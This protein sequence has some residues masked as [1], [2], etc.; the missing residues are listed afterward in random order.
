MSLNWLIVHCTGTSFLFWGNNG[1]V[2]RELYSITNL[3]WDIIAGGSEKLSTKRAAWALKLLQSP[4]KRMTFPWPRVYCSL[5]IT[6]FIVRLYK[7][8]ANN[9]KVSFHTLMQ[10]STLD[11]SYRFSTSAAGKLAMAE[12]T[13]PLPGK[14]AELSNVRPMTE[15]FLS[16]VAA[17]NNPRLPHPSQQMA[18]VCKNMATAGISL[19]PCERSSVS[20][21]YVQLRWF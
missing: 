11:E 7:V 6:T 19:C 13:M 5:L 18:L 9:A 17:A 8:V 20:H 10:H 15:C 14:P 21:L 2:Y 3:Q 4:N 16:S 1:R 12:C